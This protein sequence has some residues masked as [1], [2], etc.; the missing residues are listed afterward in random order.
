M[1]IEQI[2]E[3]VDTVEEETTMSQAMLQLLESRQLEEGVKSKAGAYEPD[4]ISKVVNWLEETY[5]EVKAFVPFKYWYSPVLDRNWMNEHRDEIELRFATGGVFLRLEDFKRYVDHS[6]KEKYSEEQ[7]QRFEKRY[8]SLSENE[9]TEIGFGSLDETNPYVKSFKDTS[10]KMLKSFLF[11]TKRPIEI[12]GSGT[13][14]ILD[15]LMDEKFRRKTTFE[16]VK[17]MIKRRILLTQIDKEGYLEDYTQRVFRIDPKFNFVTVKLVGDVHG[18]MIDEVKNNT[19]TEDE[20]QKMIAEFL[21]RR[22]SNGEA[23]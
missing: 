7:L 5:D 21:A 1:K 22:N 10:V 18:H 11:A 17:D 6:V 20:K 13:A 16:D 8:E 15:K 23:A 12:I 4:P 19:L 14:V 9:A 3:I 2:K